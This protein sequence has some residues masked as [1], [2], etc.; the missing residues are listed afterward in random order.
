MRDFDNHSNTDGDFNGYYNNNQ[1]DNRFYNNYSSNNSAYGRNND[2]PVNNNSN[3]GNN[4]YNNNGN[5]NNNYNMNNNAYGNYNNDYYNNNQ[6]GYDNR[7]NYN[8]NNINNSYDYKAENPNRVYIDD[9]KKLPLTTKILLIVFIAVFALSFLS[10]F[11]N[12]FQVTFFITRLF[13][14]MFL[15]VFVV[16]SISPVVTG[17]L[18]RRRCKVQSKATIIDVRIKRGSKGKRTYIPTYQYFYRGKEYV[19][20]T[21]RLRGFSRPQEGDIVDVLINEDKP[22]DYYIGNK[23]IEIISLILGIIFLIIPICTYIASEIAMAKY[24]MMY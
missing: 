6:Y 5:Y 16:N 9:S 23:K 24:Y 18:K 19:V 1:S 4:Y 13:P 11:I 17:T 15:L 2:Y 8:Q 14:I 12:N 22:E 21:R 3:Y 10:N 7:N 20:T